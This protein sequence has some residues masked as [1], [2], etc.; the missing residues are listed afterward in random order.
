MFNTL[1]KTAHPFMDW[2]WP[3]IEP[4]FQDLESRPLTPEN[5][6]GWLS[7]WS[8]LK[9]L[10]SETY[11]RLNV[12]TTRDTT[13]Q[14]AEQ[15]YHTFLGEVLPPAEAADQKL[16]QKFLESGQQ[17]PGFE[18]PTRNMRAEA[19]LFRT[20]NL[21][22]LTSERRLST[23]FNK[24][25]GAQTVGW[26]GEERTLSQLRPLY[27]DPDR[28]IR[29]H[30]WRLAADRQL[31]DR[32]AINAL[33]AEFMS[34]RRELAAN[35]GFSDY[36]AYRWPDML[37][38]DYTPDD[39]LS[40]H[41]AIEEAV[42][43]AAARIYEKRRQQLGFDTLRPWDLNVDPQG[44]DPLR[45]FSDV[46][47]LEQVA[48]MIFQGLD[49]ELG[50]RFETM[51]REDLLDLG[52]R[53]GK[54]PGGYCATFAVAKRPFIFMNAVGLHSDVQTLL[55]EAGHAFH[56]FESAHLPYAQQLQVPMEFAEVA[57]MAMELL[58]S[59]YLPADQGGFYSDAD[60]ARARVEELEGILLF[61]PYMAVVDAFQHWVY[62]HHDDA[63]DPA[64]CDAH[65]SKLWERFI[66]GVD[67]SGLEQEKMTGWHRK[68]HI[69]K[70]PFYYVE[71]GLAQLGAVLVWRNSLSDQAKALKQY[72]EALSLGGTVTL[73][74]L[75]ETAGARLAFDAETLSE[76]VAL[77]E[78][79]IEELDIA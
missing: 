8:H 29:E 12:A 72:R 55:H 25:V 75:F 66:P 59:P 52:N 74:E 79:K 57:S 28:E 3:Q 23:E 2:D 71:Y 64:N 76:A 78:G 41:R 6:A 30:A 34:L 45:P 58:S 42:V 40:F 44:R 24:I 37:R 53:K 22:L 10:L 70:Y 16:K 13:D 43:P 77:I 33:W 32:D 73:P 4:Y 60:V 51:R 19:E 49:P 18:I 14:D 69:H 46:G 9:L 68:L 11:S 1:P 27:Q 26:K 36:R 67:W 15:R 54:G 62:T 39:C 20:E 21:P 63:T 65:W 48:G 61:W 47:R 38:F 5:A 31:A 50:N 56:V 35:A 7:D 17:V